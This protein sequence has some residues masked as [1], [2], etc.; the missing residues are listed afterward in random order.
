MK[1]L[2][3]LTRRIGEKII[4]GDDVIISI[5]GLKGSQIRIGTEAPPEVPVYREEIYL[6][7]L[8]ERADGTGRTS[9]SCFQ[10]IHNP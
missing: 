4:I 6:K 10:K 5:V 3:I 9:D 2:L 1:P 7:I 8:K